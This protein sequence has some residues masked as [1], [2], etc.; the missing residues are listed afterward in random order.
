M[1]HWT[2]L[3]SDRILAKNGLQMAK[4]ALCKDSPAAKWSFLQMTFKSV[5]LSR[6]MKLRHV[7]NNSDNWLGFLF[8]VFEVIGTSFWVSGTS[9]GEVMTSFDLNLTSPSCSL[10]L[11]VGWWSGWAA[12]GFGD[13]LIRFIVSSQ[14][15]FELLIGTWLSEL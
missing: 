1:V 15:I 5:K 3:P 10:S 2:Y 7:W 4:M 11:L 12:W 8:K 14:T 6:V 9:T 13:G